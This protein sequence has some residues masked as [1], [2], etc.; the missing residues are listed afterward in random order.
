MGKILAFLLVWFRHYLNYVAGY[1]S[2]AVPISVGPVRRNSPDQRPLSLAISSSFPSS[3][4]CLNS[5]SHLVRAGKPHCPS[6]TTRYT[7]TDVSS[8][9]SH[10]SLHIVIN[11]LFFITYSCSK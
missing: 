1:P 4:T 8:I 11:N 5:V 7:S 10:T 9:S 3:F 6:S 2:A